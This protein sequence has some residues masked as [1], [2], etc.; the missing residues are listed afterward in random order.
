[1]Y[2][3]NIP[4]QLA[5]QHGVGTYLHFI[6]RL[7]VHSQGRLAV[8]V[9]Y[10][11][12]TALTFRL[13]VQETQRLARDPYLTDRFRE[14]VDKGEGD[15]FRSFDLG[16]FVDRVGLR[17]LERLILASSFFSTSAQLSRKELE[18][19]AAAIIRDEFEDAAVSL[20]QSVSFEHGDLNPSQLAKLMENLLL[21]PLDDPVLDVAQRQAL[22]EAAQAKFGPEVISPILQRILPSIS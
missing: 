4:P 9:S 2:N 16:R 7:I 11:T 21:G 20:Y 14:S 22:I 10:D 13:L 1:V 15:V 6:R 3:R 8:N 5:E 19:Q 18:G 17:P 12:S